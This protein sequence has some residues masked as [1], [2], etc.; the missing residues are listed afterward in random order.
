MP[1]Q[2]VRW[3]FFLWWNKGLDFEP[4]GSVVKWRF[5]SLS[6]QKPRNRRRQ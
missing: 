1:A 3:N 5:A 6:E 4:K 2:R